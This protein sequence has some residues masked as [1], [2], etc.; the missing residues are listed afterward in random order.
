MRL[1]MS[2]R[3]ITLAWSRLTGWLVANV[4]C[5][6]GRQPGLLSSWSGLSRPTWAVSLREDLAAGQQRRQDEHAR[7]LCGDRLGDAAIDGV[8]HLLE[9]RHGV[10]LHGERLQHGPHRLRHQRLAAV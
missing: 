1:V 5:G 7:R 9:P 8:L 3:F 2:K 10:M 6:S 4:M